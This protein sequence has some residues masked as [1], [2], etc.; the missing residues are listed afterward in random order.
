MEL[1][2]ITALVTATRSRLPPRPD[3]VLYAGSSGW[4]YSS[5]R[6]E[7]Y[8][9]GLQGEELL[10]FYAA[11]LPSVEL[12]STG[13]R[14]PSEEQF[15]KWAAA[16]PDGFRFAVKAPRRV[17]RDVATVEER[18]RRLGDRLGPLRVV[19]ESPRDDGLL[20]LLLGSTDLRLALD[21]RDGSWDGVDVAPA[22]RVGDWDADAPFR[23]LRFRD[24]PYDE[25]AL[26]A[27][28][29]RIRPLLAAGVDVYAYFR[30]EDEP[31]A[32]R[33]AERLLEL[34]DMS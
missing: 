6:P 34:V 17:L 31:S 24:P 30:H 7:F 26:A 2:G 29:E 22:V 5:W 33:Y 21:L 16:V 10:G 19:V 20:A 4:S 18:V 32:P 8:P 3:G 13:Y 11:R 1:S 15:G 23:Y 25:A 27:L 14:L 12:N 9:D 28:A